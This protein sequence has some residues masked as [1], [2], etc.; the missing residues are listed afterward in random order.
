MLVHVLD[1]NDLAADKNWNSQIAA[2]L[3]IAHRFIGSVHMLLSRKFVKFLL[4]SPVAN[5]LQKFLRY[6]KFSEET[7]FSTLNYNPQFG[8]PG[9]FTGQKAVNSKTKEVVRLRKIYVLWYKS[10]DERIQISFSFP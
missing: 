5:D 3:F 1:C 7:F 6:T 9:A 10:E 4:T 8:A 2:I